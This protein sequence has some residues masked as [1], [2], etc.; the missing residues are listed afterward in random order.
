MALTT[1]FAAA[2]GAA[3]IGGLGGVIGAAIAGKKKSSSALPIVAGSSIVG[4][5]LGALLFSGIGDSCPKCPPA[6][7][8][9]GSVPL[10]TTPPTRGIP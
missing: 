4:A 8:G 3:L 2:V 6:T 7:G 9:P 1:G 5:T 10:A